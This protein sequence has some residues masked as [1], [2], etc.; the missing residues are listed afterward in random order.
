MRLDNETVRDLLLAIEE[1]TD[2]ERDFTY[3]NFIAVTFRNKE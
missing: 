1:V 3:E 2:G